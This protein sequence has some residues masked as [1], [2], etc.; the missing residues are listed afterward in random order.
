[1][2]D[3]RERCAEAEV[4]PLAA[5]LSSVL[6]VPAVEV[7]IVGVEDVLQFEGVL[8]ATDAPTDIELDDL[9]TEDRQVIDPSTWPTREATLG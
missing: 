2:A 8:A 4:A 1:M 3:L 5:C 9:A 7:A 6:A